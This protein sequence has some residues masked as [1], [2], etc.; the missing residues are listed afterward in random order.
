MCSA[1]LLLQFAHDTATNKK[2]IMEDRMQEDF[3]NLQ[4]VKYFVSYAYLYLWGRG[5]SHFLKMY[6]LQ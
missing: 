6:C 1:F 5:I 3:F 4:L 2:S